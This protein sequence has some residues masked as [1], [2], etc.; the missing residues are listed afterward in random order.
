[1]VRRPARRQG[2][3]SNTQAKPRAFD[4]IGCTQMLPATEMRTVAAAAVS[5]TASHRSDHSSLMRSG[6]TIWRATCGS[7]LRTAITQTTTGRLPMGRL[8]WMENA[9]TGWFAA[10]YALNPETVRSAKRAMTAPD[11]RDLGLGIRVGG[12][13]T[14]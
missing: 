6:S 4:D 13:L 8:G 12:T 10:S 9:V 7:G 2:A 3:R 5:G 14:P 1:M 11:S